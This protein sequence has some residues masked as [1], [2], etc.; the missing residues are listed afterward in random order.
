MMQKSE[1]VLRE[2]YQFCKTSGAPAAQ[3]DESVCESKEEWRQVQDALDQLEDLEMVHYASIPPRPN[4]FS[5]EVL[6]KGIEYCEQ[7]NF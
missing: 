5:V 2:V 7:H 1:E 6:D 3:I 4:V